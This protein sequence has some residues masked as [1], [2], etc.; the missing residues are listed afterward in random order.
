MSSE[1]TILMGRF[2]S[3][4]GELSLDEVLKDTPV[5]NQTLLSPDPPLQGSRIH[6]TGPEPE[7]AKEMP[8][9][10]VKWENSWWQHVARPLWP[11]HLCSNCGHSL[12]G[13]ANVE[14]SKELFYLVSTIQ[15]TL[16]ISSLNSRRKTGQCSLWGPLRQGLDWIT[17]AGA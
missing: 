11:N 8:L 12:L 17:V 6:I 13:N 14:V 2:A 16:L 10:S 3:Q 1:E 7:R 5:G 9:C 15:I 4:R